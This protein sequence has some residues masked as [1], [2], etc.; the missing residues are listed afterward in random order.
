MPVATTLKSGRDIGGLF[1]RNFSDFN[2]GDYIGILINVHVKR[3]HMNYYDF[4]K[5]Q[6]HP[7]SFKKVF[8]TGC[9]IN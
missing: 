6:S 7:R 2:V 9:K 5:F 8:G 4:F 1:L 3:L